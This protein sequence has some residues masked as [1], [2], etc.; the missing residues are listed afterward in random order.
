MSLACRSEAPELVLQVLDEATGDPTPARVE[1]VDASGTSFIASNALKVAGDCGWYPVH[2]WIGWWAQVQMLRALRAEVPNPFTGTSQF[3]VRG[4]AHVDLPSGTYRVRAFKGIEY[5]VVEREIQIVAGKS[6]TLELVMSRWIDLPGENWYSADDHLHIARP[7]PRFDERIAT[8]MEAEDLHV[9][10]LLQMGLAQELY[11]TPQYAFGERSIHQGPAGLLAT[12][13][14]NPRTH[15][16]GHAI[17]LGAE[18]WLDAP[19]TY[20][21]YDRLWQ[22]AHEAGGV[23]GFAH[24]GLGG[25][26]EGIA[27]WAP[28]RLLDFLEV[29]GFGLPY[30][31]IWYDLL[32]LGLR[33]A[34][35]AGTDYPCGPS[36]PGRERF[37]TR[38]EGPLSYRA[39][40]EAVR[41]GKTFV[42]NGPMLDLRLEGVDIGGETE[43][44]EP[45]NVLVRGRVRFDPSRDAVTR[46]ELVQAG[47]VVASA[48]AGDKTGEFAIETWLPID[49]STWIALRAS[50]TKIG[51]TPVAGMEFL[52]QALTH[53]PRATA[54]DV[55][56]SASFPKNGQPR[57]SAA[58]TA[59]IWITVSG[60]PR[61]EDQAPAR[62]AARRLL[63]LLDELEGRFED[64]SLP[65][66]A[67]FPGRG[68]GVGEEGLRAG[69][70]AL[71]ESVA[72]ARRNYRELLAGESGGES[73]GEI[74]STPGSS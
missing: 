24:W 70:A 74:G 53:L 37:Y 66:M 34:P 12:G 16:L 39:W 68:D 25:A 55:L 31:E 20:L 56:G 33:V 18:R 40:V 22:A 73:A 36:L 6:R 15:V 13:Q 59:P 46:L 41:A 1:I 65:T 52:K 19:E 60:G 69:R 38:V 61:L 17:T 58:H 28:E 35:T 51:E 50:G 32:N 54:G 43:I 49:S 29:L 11:I 45:R 30:Y 47:K 63:G 9:A 57:A 2:N 64:G 44:P 5:H 3:Y 10:N 8:W 48:R 27:T 42:T 4:S 23:N 14:E 71:L 72:R 7:H 21:A 26:D 67:G 62:A